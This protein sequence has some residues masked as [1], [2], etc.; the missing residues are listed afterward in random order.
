M[1]FPPLHMILCFSSQQG[2]F[3]VKM[4][5]YLKPN[6]LTSSP[7]TTSHDYPKIYIYFEAGYPIK[8]KSHGNIVPSSF[9]KGGNSFF[10]LVA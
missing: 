3:L 2:S 6:L 7:I 1:P 10:F 9:L 4:L 5:V 8:P